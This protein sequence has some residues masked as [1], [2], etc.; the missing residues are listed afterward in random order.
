MMPKILGISGSFRA[1]FRLS[2][3]KP[4]IE[5]VKRAPDIESLES[6]FIR[7]I[8]HNLFPQKS[9]D[10]NQLHHNL[11]AGIS[12]SEM[13]LIV[14]LWNAYIKK[15]E[16]ELVSLKEFFP[17]PHK[18]VKKNYLLKMVRETDAIIISG[19]VYFGDRSS[20][21]HQF[22]EMLK[23]YP[24]TLKAC[25]GK[26]YAGISV[27][28]KRNGGQETNLIY[29]ILDM[30]NIGFLAVG[31]DSETTAQYGGTCCAGTIGTVFND[32]YGINTARGVGRRVATYLQ[33]KNY[34]K[35]IKTKVKVA[36]LI[37]QDSEGMTH[38]YLKTITSLFQKEI[39][40]NIIDIFSLK[41]MRCLACDICPEKIGNDEEYRCK[42]GKQDDF[43]TIHKQLLDNDIIIPVAVSLQDSSKL[44]SNYQVFIERTRYL[45][46]GDYALSDTLF[47]PLIIRDIGSTDE[48]HVRLITSLIRHNTI[49]Y[50][51]LIETL[52]NGNFLSQSNIIKNFARLIETG[53]ECAI[54]RLVSCNI[55]DDLQYNPVGYVLESS[56]EDDLDKRRSA[57]K[58]RNK[59]LHNQLKRRI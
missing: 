17:S 44:K 36:F 2:S 32:A 11:I 27:G 59:R 35:K 38:E 26:L 23:T 8:D 40:Y 28:A 55:Q 16:I 20:L 30:V 34:T 43:I 13:A 15:S 58:N 51:P 37:L 39:D 53:K 33:K 12:N 29:Q 47:A 9:L 22:I 42:I 56:L 52:H 25:Q 7:K 5:K 57:V 31:N 45:R 49:V 18:I 48:I 4:F 54:A 6:L 3:A 10:K 50:K 1:S 46:R 21:V 41:I 24:E 14:C 19:P